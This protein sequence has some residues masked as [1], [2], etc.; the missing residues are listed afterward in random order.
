MWPS[1]PDRPK[2]RFVMNWTKRWAA[3][4]D[5]PPDNDVRCLVAARPA[6]PTPHFPTPSTEETC[7]ES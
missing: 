1:A 5:G 6:D 2:V 3:V 7:A 4:A